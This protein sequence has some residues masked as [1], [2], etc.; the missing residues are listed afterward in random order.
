MKGI[1]YSGGVVLILDFG[2]DYKHEVIAI[3][4]GIYLSHGSFIQH[5]I[6]ITIVVMVLELLVMVE[7][8]VFPIKNKR[9]R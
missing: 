3:P 8:M 5:A 6:V 7:A 9:S 4:S 2:M 1:I